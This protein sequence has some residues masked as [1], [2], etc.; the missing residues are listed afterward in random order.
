MCS[1]LFAKR[2][3]ILFP[4]ELKLDR[5]LWSVDVIHVGVCVGILGKEPTVLV[6]RHTSLR[7]AVPA[8]HRAVGLGVS[9]LGCQY[10]HCRVD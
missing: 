3:L 7:E 4:L 5:T 2:D 6:L 10:W 1:G 8:E 9:R